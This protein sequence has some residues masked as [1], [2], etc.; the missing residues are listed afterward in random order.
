MRS[1][2]L[3]HKFLKNCYIR[4][5][6]NENEYYKKRYIKTLIRRQIELDYQLENTPVHRT[7]EMYTKHPKTNYLELMRL[8]PDQ[9]NSE[10]FAQI[11]RENNARQKRVY[12]DDLLKDEDEGTLGIKDYLKL[13]IDDYNKLKKLQSYHPK[14]RRD[15]QNYLAK[16]DKL[17]QGYKGNLNI[18]FDMIDYIKEVI[19]QSKY[20]KNSEEKFAISTIYSKLCTLFSKCFD[21]I[22][23]EGKLD[24]STIELIEE[25]IKHSGNI[26]TQ[27]KYIG[28]IE[29]FLNRF[30]FTISYQK[31]KYIVYARKSLIFKKELNMLYE[32]LITEDSIFFKTNDLL[33]E[34]RVVLHQR[35]IFCM[36]MYYSGLREGEM[37]S[38][39]VKDIYTADGLITID[40][41]K[42]DVVDSLKTH[43]SKRRIEFMIDDKKY[44][45]I[46][47]EYLNYL[48]EKKIKYL[49][50]MI[51]Q[52]REI[53]KKAVQK[54]SFFLQCN[55]IIQQITGRYASLHS[56]R[57]T[58]VT[59]SM[60]KLLMQSKK[61]K[62][63]FYNYIN[64]IGHLG[65][66]VTLHY[67]MHIGYVLHYHD[68]E[69][70]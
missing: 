54:P 45:S 38:R 3:S 18:Y 1:L 65:P 21:I 23:K 57:H 15:H 50:P 51:S 28:V 46:F 32:K 4:I 49:F 59:K 7:L 62:A 22:I 43:S 9:I 48:E 39:E 58:Y 44:F 35:F 16:L 70:F 2:Q 13:L 56:F 67:Y 17:K 31:G 63:D 8:F 11:E 42:N 34:R 30:G 20:H 29:P 14:S 55:Q 41:H 52:D 19:Y 5:T 24:I 37:W 6:K 69:L 25:K 47:K 36:L 33:V 40:V 60:R 64:M 66:D 61:H 10:Y 53:S 12:P 26:A 68:L 27:R